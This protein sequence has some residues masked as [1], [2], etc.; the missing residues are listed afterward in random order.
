MGFQSVTLVLVFYA[1]YAEERAYH[2]SPFPWDWVDEKKK[3]SFGLTR[4]VKEVPWTPPNAKV[5]ASIS[6]EKRE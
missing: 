4:N 6:E 5:D 3:F 1:M 2:G